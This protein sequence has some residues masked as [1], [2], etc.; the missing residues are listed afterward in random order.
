VLYEDLSPQEA[1][2]QLMTRGLKPE[3]DED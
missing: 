2:D 1:L 3:L